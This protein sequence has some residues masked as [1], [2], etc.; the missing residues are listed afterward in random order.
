MICRSEV[1]E[2]GFLVTG[3][4]TSS[5]ELLFTQL[6]DRLRSKDKGPTVLLRSSDASN[7]K[8][9]LK[10]IIRDTTNQKEI[11]EDEEV[12]IQDEF[13][14]MIW[15]TWRVKNADGARD[16]NCSTTTSRY[17]INMSNYTVVTESSLSFKIAKRLTVSCFRN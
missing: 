5:Q 2:A 14:C 1:L 4:N 13:V 6:S 15:Q 16:E 3:P 10:Q 17:C 7:L 8:N 9:T 12:N 11:A